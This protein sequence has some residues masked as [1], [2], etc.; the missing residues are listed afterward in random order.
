MAWREWW[1]QAQGMTQN[2]AERLLDLEE[3][4]DGVG[5][6]RHPGSHLQV[7]R[8]RD[9]AEASGL[10]PDSDRSDAG[11]LARLE[12]VRTRRD[13]LRAAMN[14]LEKSAA[15]PHAGPGWSQDVRASVTR[16]HNA[17]E[18]HIR[19]VEGPEGLFEAV[20]ATAP[21]LAHDAEDLRGEHHD[22]MR[23]IGSV[24]RALDDSSG[25]A[26]I[27]RRVMSLLAR[28]VVHRQRGSDLV[29]N[30]YNIDI[31]DSG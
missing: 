1:A 27:R 6:F 16:L 25:K 9:Q 4:A 31:G 23:S 22:L 11:R 30:A 29:Y 18:T 7:E 20:V 15:R 28:L 3:T 5:L 21:R 26:V 14:D 10:I 17:L 8:A 19:D 13:E 2:D 12:S 24:D